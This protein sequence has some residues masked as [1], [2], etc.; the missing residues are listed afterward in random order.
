M[1]GEALVTVEIL[2]VTRGAVEVGVDRL[3]AEQRAHCSNALKLS[4]KGRGR[5]PIG[6]GMLP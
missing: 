3:F 2:R 6:V 4:S 5:G 1:D